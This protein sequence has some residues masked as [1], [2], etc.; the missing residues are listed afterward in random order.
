MRIADLLKN[1]QLKAFVGDEAADIYDIAYDSRRVQAGGAFVAISGSRQD[2]LDYLPQ[3]YERGASLIVAERMPEHRQGV[4]YAIVGNARAAL[5]EMAANMYYHPEKSLHIVG[6]TGTN[7]KTTTA[8][9][10][11][12]L[13]EYYG[14]K[15]GL[16]GTINNMSGGKVIESTHTT[17]E[18]LELLGILD[19]MREENCHNVVMEVSSHALDQGR[20]ACLPFKG[21]VF[22]NLTQDHLDYHGTMEEY[23]HAKLRLFEMLAEDGYGVINADDAAAPRFI[24]ACRGRVFTYGM[25]EQAVFHICEYHID[26]EGTA[27][28]VRYHGEQYLMHIPLTGRFNIYNSAAAACAA[29]AEGMGMQQ[30]IEALSYAPQVAGRFEKVEAGQDFTVVVDYAH[31]PDGLQNVL[32]AARELRPCRLIAVFGCGGDRDKTK[33]PIMG[34]IGAEMADYCIITS[35]NPRTEEPQ[36]I[37][38]M[39]VEGA[40]GKGAEPEIYVS[41]QE[42]IK[43]AVFIAQKGDVIVIAG[44]GHEDYQILG[45]VKVHFDDR[46]IA[47]AAIC[48]RLNK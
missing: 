48:E 3:A 27:F 14:T 26:T 31:T 37:I 9:L 25:S 47:R 12:W 20:V 10:I 18:S 22:T 41:R 23:L 44:K 19:T 6:V 34:G 28:T 4:S 24:A 2:G 29:L 36:S 7:G 16:L 32:A 21:A 33:R 43:R 35:D 13:W 46:E 42:A 30:I 45:T 11:K 39:V 17:P 1:V 38:D 15:S 8:K 40:R 5:G